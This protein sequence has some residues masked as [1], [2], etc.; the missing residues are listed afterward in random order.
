[1]RGVLGCGD[2]GEEEEVVMRPAEEGSGLVVSEK[3][4]FFFLVME[5]KLFLEWLSYLELRYFV[6]ERADGQGCRS[7]WM[8][9]VWQ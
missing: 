6:L 3:V 5:I 4:R 2:A 1:M 9:A 8:Y 7:L